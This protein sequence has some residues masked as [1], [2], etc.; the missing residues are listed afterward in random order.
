MTKIIE[1]DSC[2]ECPNSYK[3]SG[4]PVWNEQWICGSE[5]K[6]IS[7]EWII[8]SWCPLPDKRRK[9]QDE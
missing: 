9:R 7:E 2:E 4:R 1:V 5:D 8:P 6:V 3:N